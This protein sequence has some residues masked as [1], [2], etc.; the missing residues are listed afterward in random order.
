MMRRRLPW[1]DS[2]WPLRIGKKHFMRGSRGTGPGPP[3]I[4]EIVG[5]DMVELY[6]THPGQK[7]DPVRP[8]PT[9]E[10]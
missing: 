4:F 10:N 6:R 9:R 5:F 8:L 1:F 7:L 3:L 2:N